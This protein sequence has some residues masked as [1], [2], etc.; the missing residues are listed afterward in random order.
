[1]NSMRRMPFQDA[2]DTPSL[3]TV[4]VT[5]L[6]TSLAVI[7]I[8]LFT[9]YV[10]KQYE[11][12]SH[13]QETLSQKVSP[14][15]ETA[16]DIR[17]QLQDHFQRYHLS[18]DPDPGDPSVL[19]IIVPD[20][21]LNFE[22][23]KGTLSPAASQFLT[24]SMPAYG[25]LLCGP[26]REKIDSLVIEGHTDDRGSDIHNLKLS[27]ERSFNVMVKALDV[28][29]ESSPWIYGCFHEKTSASGRGRQDLVYEELGYPNRD[30]SRRVIF[31]IRLR[32]SDQL[33]PFN[34]SAGLGEISP[35]RS[36]Q[37]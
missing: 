32:S 6:M 20:E 36:A 12:E 35:V 10:T 1:M 22:F 19:R 9:A 24:E 23:G 17:G 29:A 5:D 3:L 11:S 28:I 8:L 31:K 13:A 25:S 16:A 34:R 33:R 26:L 4:G 37:F 27:Q 18:L 30:K 2:A 15:Q 21:L 7:F 14:L